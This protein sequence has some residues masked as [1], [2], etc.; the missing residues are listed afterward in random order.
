MIL[1]AFDKENRMIKSEE[2]AKIVGVSR[3]TVSRVINNYPNVSEDTRKKVLEAI[4]EYKYRPNAYARTLAGK[5]SETIGV[6]FV[7][8]EAPESQRRLYH[9]DFFTTYLDAIID[10]ANSKG[11]YVLVQTI[12]C[13]EEYEK[14]DKAFCEQRVDGGILIGTRKDSLKYIRDESICQHMV[15]VDI[16][17]ELVPTHFMEQGLV[18]VINS[19]DYQA[20]YQ[21]VNYLIEYGHEKIG[22]IKG[23]EK[24]LSAFTRY[25]GYLA[26][27]RDNG[28]SFCKDYIL[29]GDFNQEKARK[30]MEKAIQKGTLPTAYICANDYM[31]IAA[32]E[33]LGEH[34]IRVPE[35]VS[36]IGFD[37]TQTGELMQPKLTTL[38]PDFFAMSKK[39]VEIIHQHLIDNKKMNAENIFEYDV[40]LIK[41]GS[42]RKIN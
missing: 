42:V 21:A 40:E 1:L 32:I 38:S 20:V 24:T 31:A 30:E 5:R 41:R 15:M 3:S 25:D 13:N 23:L 36:F 27:I 4:E 18:S 8:D 11:Y 39:S 9:N 14:I 17:P 35:D 10:I 6:F 12:T 7:I 29:E 16:D 22:F 34:K 37:N 2:I 26:A 19:K 33:C 28:L